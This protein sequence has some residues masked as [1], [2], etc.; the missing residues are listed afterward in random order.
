MGI[1]GS[2]MYKATTIATYVV[3]VKTERIQCKLLRVTR[4]AAY[5]INSRMMIRKL[6]AYLRVASMRVGSFKGVE[7]DAVLVYIDFVLTQIVD[8]LVAFP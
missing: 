8:L 4:F 6:L 2:V 1:S 5:D 3:S 7:R